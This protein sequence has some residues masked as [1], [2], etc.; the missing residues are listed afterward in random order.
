M[1]VGLEDFAAEVERKVS[2]AYQLAEK[3]DIKGAVEIFGDIR[4]FGEQ[5]GLKERV[6]KLEKEFQ[7]SI[8]S[9]RDQFRSYIKQGNPL[10]PERRIVILADSLGLPRPDQPNNV[11]DS[12]A[13][14]YPFALREGV[15][16]RNAKDGGPKTAIDPL[17]QRYA[18]SETVL[19]N[20]ELTSVTDADVIIHVGLNDF[21][22][23]IF[24]ER[25][26]L[27]MKLLPNDLVNRIVCF[28]QA[29]MYRADIIRHYSEFCYVPIEKWHANIRTI[30]DK[31]K[32]GGARSLT[33]FTIIQLPVRVEAHTPNYRYNVVR[34][35]LGLYDAAR[36]GL[37]DLL[38][39]DRMFWERG[40]EAHM[41]SDL[42]H[43]SPKGHL[44]ICNRM[45]ERLF[46]VKEYLVKE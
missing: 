44:Y 40:Y 27:A 10:E 18:T 1:D 31:V 28:S 2:K 14:N 23:R 46:G 30:V 43:L 29:N 12:Q 16:R 41:H 7:A 32:E 37:F 9:E 34:Y 15:K 35:N 42:M 13:T 17:C 36:R 39:V 6:D 24:M 20:L 26:R 11:I 33:W 19:Q 4:N 45:I 22:R 25:Q 21:S 8:R 5:P 38:D 3:K